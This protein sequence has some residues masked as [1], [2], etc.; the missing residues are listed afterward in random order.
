MDRLMRYQTTLER[1][2]SRALGELLHVIDRR[3]P[4]AK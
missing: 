3:K 1:Q 2:F 4:K